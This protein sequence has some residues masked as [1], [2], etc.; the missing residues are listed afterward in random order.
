MIAGPQQCQ[1]VH[2]HSTAAAGGHRG[3]GLCACS[4]CARYWCGKCYK[5]Y[6]PPD[7]ATLD[8]PT[9]RAQVLRSSWDAAAT[10]T[11]SRSMGLPSCTGFGAWCPR[12]CPC[13]SWWWLYWAMPCV[14][15]EYAGL[16]GASPR[17][18]GPQENFCSLQC[19]VNTPLGI[20]PHVGPTQVN[21]ACST[22][23]KEG[24]VLDM[25]PG[26]K[27]GFDLNMQAASSWQ[28]A[29]FAPPAPM[30]LIAQMPRRPCPSISVRTP[31]AA[32]KLPS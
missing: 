13:R 10:L 3:P 9:M 8:F 30:P 6:I 19:C 24:V 17:Q 26:C 18:N 32:V 11:R 22:C 25:H 1:R 12:W 20:D 14:C 4:P 5:C 15:I 23:S 27:W 29:A 7:L 21:T 31:I 2:P 16:E 28:L